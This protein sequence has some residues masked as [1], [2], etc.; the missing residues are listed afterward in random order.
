MNTGH[1]SPTKVLT[2]SRNTPHYDFHS[3]RHG[4][5]PRILIQPTTQGKFRARTQPVRREPWRNPG[6]PGGGAQTRTTGALPLIFDRNHTKAR[7]FI[8]A[9]TS[10]LR[11][12]E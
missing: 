3:D 11:L 1:P 7:L 6:G 2:R 10:Y 8:R 12:N 9:L 4:D 5:D